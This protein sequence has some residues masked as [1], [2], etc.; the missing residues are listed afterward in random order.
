MAAMQ[1][2]NAAED[3]DFDASEPEVDAEA[4]ESA[5]DLN[6]PDITTLGSG[7]KIGGGYGR[8][9]RRSEMFGEDADHAIGR[10]TS[11][12]LYA[13]A[14]QFPTCV[15]LRVWKWENGVPTGLGTIDATATE[16][17]FV[18]K[19][20][21]AMPR[22]G[23]G[24]AQFRLRPID[25]RGQE[26]GQE[27]TSVISEHHT[28]IRRM[29]EAE[30]EER[31]MRMY[32]R[33]RFRG[34]EDHGNNGGPPQ[35]VVEAPQMSDSGEHMSH[36]VDRML[37]VVEARAKALEDSL[38][39]ERER[40]REEEQRRGQERIDLA[41]NAAQGVQALTERAM[42]DEAAR[43]ERAMRVQQEQS[44]VLVTTLTSIFA[45]QASMAAQQSEAQRRADEYRLEQ[46]RQRAE[47]ERRDNEER[48]KREREEYEFRRARER[49][50]ADVRLKQE[51]DEAIRKFEQQKMELEMRLARERE[52][53]DR[54]ERR[55]KDEREAR[56]RWFSEERA[57]REERENREAKE[58]EEA[59]ARRE[60]IERE[61]IRERD[62]ERQRQHDLRIKEMDAQAQRDREHAERMAS[63][64]RLEL[65][66]KTNAANSDPLANTMRLF[67]QF[68]IPK[69]EIFPRVFGF[70]GKE[71]DDEDEEGK[72]PGWMAA[73]PAAMGMVGELAKAMA[74]RNGQGAPA[75]RPPPQYVAPQPPPQPRQAAPPFVAGPPQTRP[76]AAPPRPP[77]AI[78]A[79]PE[80]AAPPRRAPVAAE[81][82]AAPEDGVV[83][84]IPPSSPGALPTSEEVSAAA[85][86][87]APAAS[88]SEVAAAAGLNLKAQKTARTGLRSLIKKVSNAEEEKWE[89]LI[90]TAVMQ[91]PNIFHYIKAV[92]VKAAMIENGA[93][94]TL[95][96]RVM[97]AMRAS[98]LVPDDLPYGDGGEA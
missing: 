9:N 87:T 97:A 75:P 28:G 80:E 49:E 73:L 72:D 48:L 65:E 36:V 74:A 26:L 85:P 60:A 62:A 12:R 93:D 68:G 51:R 58:R 20:F 24:R 63:M 5:D 52:E 53:L 64:Q 1:K 86:T 33:G 7:P 16:E 61:E 25:I 79:P 69:E 18:Q 54:K 44:Q 41:T 13:Q 92:T 91:E 40:L 55:E 82:A 81:A 19:F 38:D 3:D 95:A 89:E 76:Q 11:P 35:V 32:G 27:V 17:D 70:G 46:E 30:E 84:M 47:R 31:E 77:R 37:E 29:R 59:R 42:K 39:M 21:S 50:E 78:Q 71:K 8:G 66:A 57:R 23:E 67:S 2:F 10:A 34:E 83:R 90:A 15:Q 98:S 94:E 14:S 43:A 6:D 56:E 45:Q 22:R 96:A 88:L 4:D